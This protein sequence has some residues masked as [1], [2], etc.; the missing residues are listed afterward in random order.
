MLAMMTSKK[1]TRFIR[2]Q[3]RVLATDRIHIAVAPRFHHAAK[4]SRGTRKVST[5][6]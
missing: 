3:L 5:V 6:T 1:R 4:V 2:A